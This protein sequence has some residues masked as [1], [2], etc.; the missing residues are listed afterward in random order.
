MT[1]GIFG[2]VDAKFLPASLLAPIAAGLQIT[3]GMAGQSI[4]V[5]AGVAFF[6]SLLVAA[7]T[8]GV[9]R[10]Y[11]LAFLT[12]LLVLSN[13]LVAIAPNLTVL[14]LA[15][16]LPGSRWAA[17]GT[18]ARHD[19]ASGSCPGYPQGFGYTVRRSVRRYCLRS[20]VRQLFR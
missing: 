15:R 13:L 17:S 3:E 16:V 7:V 11:V 6:T 19:D 4:T 14:L 20:P 2:I 5:T 9:D 1:L 12:L 8:N 10:R 18:L